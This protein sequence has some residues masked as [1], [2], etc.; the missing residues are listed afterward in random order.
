ME[1]EIMGIMTEGG[2]SSGGERREYVFALALGLIPG[3][4]HAVLSLRAPVT[5]GITHCHF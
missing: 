3:L 2:Q 4:Q 5:T 1:E